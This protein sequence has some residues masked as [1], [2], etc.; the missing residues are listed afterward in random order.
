MPIRLP[1]KTNRIVLAG[2]TGTGKTVAGI[3]HLSNFEF[4]KEAGGQPWVI[5]DFKEDEHLNSLPNLQESDLSYIPRKNDYGIFIVHCVPADTRGSLK[6]ASPF[7]EFLI[8]LWERE[9]IG[10]F[11]DEGY[12]IGDSGGLELCLTQGRSKRIPMIVCTQRPVWISRFC[13]SEASF[14]QCFDLT[15]KRD[16]Q[17]VEGFVPIDHDEE[18]PLAEHESFYYDVGKDELFRFAPVPPMKEIRKIFA[19]KLRRKMVRI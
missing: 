9:N 16:W 12:V 17:T 18:S 10:L 6:H 11:V 1:Q 19:A 14:I 2:R 3:W 5:V 15:D 4:E 7:D 13:F 8:K